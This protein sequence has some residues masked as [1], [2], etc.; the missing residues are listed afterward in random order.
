[1]SQDQERA[2]TRNSRKSFSTDSRNIPQTDRAVSED[3]T[4]AAASW[5]MYGT[6][7][8]RVNT[9][10]RAPAEKFVNSAVSLVR[11]ILAGGTQS[12]PPLAAKPS[13]VDA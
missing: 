13:A 3:L 8:H 12:E 11:P 5:A 2:R 1:M 10:D 4:A 7:K 9:Q 6:A